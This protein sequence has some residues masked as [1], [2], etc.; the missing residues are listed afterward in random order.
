MVSSQLDGILLD[1]SSTHSESIVGRRELLAS[2]IQ[3]FRQ[4]IFLACFFSTAFSHFIFLFHFL[5]LL[6]AFF[7]A[8]YRAFSA[9][10]SSV[11]QSRSFFGV[12]HRN[13]EL[14]GSQ[15]LFRDGRIWILVS[16]RYDRWA[17]STDF[18]A[19]SVVSLLEMRPDLIRIQP[20]TRIPIL[21]IRVVSNL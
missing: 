4:H 20:R 9:V 1:Q 10:G 13:G 19:F 16:V 17:R 7:R 5:V 6:V 2:G 21:R 18:I 15:L 8:K 3:H 11:E 14:P 12:L